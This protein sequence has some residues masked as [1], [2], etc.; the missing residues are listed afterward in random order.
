MNL[1]LLSQ[2]LI[3]RKFKWTCLAKHVTVPRTVAMLVVPQRHYK[4]CED[5]AFGLRVVETSLLGLVLVLNLLILPYCNKFND[6]D[7]ITG[8]VL[9]NLFLILRK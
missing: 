4:T 2:E 9:E 6:Y 8:L 1:C 5:V 7:V 3:E